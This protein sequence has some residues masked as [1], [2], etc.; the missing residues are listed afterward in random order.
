MSHTPPRLL[1]VGA[2]ATPFA[3]GFDTG[4]AHG[5][6]IGYAHGYRQAELDMADAW[7]PVAEAVRRTANRPTFEELQRLRGAADVASR[8]AEDGYLAPGRSRGAA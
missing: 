5:Y 7:I 4:Y 2:P 1:R 8:H 3:D 6:D